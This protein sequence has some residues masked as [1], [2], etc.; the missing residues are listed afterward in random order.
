M[1]QDFKTIAEKWVNENLGNDKS[2]VVAVSK[3]EL[4]RLNWTATMATDILNR[5]LNK[6]AEFVRQA[7]SFFD[8]EVTVTL[9]KEDIFLNY[10]DSLN[11]TMVVAESFL[12]ELDS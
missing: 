8:D 11:E 7:I 9:E 4:D 2:E 6:Y 12:E 5:V 3:A 1:D 10:V